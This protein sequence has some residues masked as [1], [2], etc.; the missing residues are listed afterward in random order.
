MS[1]FLEMLETDRNHPRP[2]LQG[3]T[4]SQARGWEAQGPGFGPRQ[5]LQ[6]PINMDAFQV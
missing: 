4:R 6:N 2:W 3:N 5:Y 1:S